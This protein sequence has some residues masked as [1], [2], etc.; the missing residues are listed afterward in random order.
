M[1]TDSMRRMLIDLILWEDSQEE[2]EMLMGFC[3]TLFE[4]RAAQRREELE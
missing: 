1:S 3:S 4:K 2:L